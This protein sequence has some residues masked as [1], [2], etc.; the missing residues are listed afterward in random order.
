MERIVVRESGPG[1]IASIEELYPDAFPDEDLL[2]LVRELLKAKP[3]AL[4]LVGIIGSS[5]V[6]HVIF[7]T[8]GLAGSNNKVAL[9]GPLVVTAARRKHGIGSAI[10]RAGLLRLE[11][12]SMTHVF[13]LGDPGFY[14]RLGF[15]P[16]PHV[17]PPYPLP[18]EWRGAWQSMS[19]SSAV[20]PLP[21][22]TLSAPQPW[23]KPAL[24]TS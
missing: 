8:C 10:V 24:W 9:L 12:S 5:L 21:V 19:L 3:V 22:G 13:V 2:P 20:P 1:D 11:S 18:A 23:L 16:E 6:A 15:E 4:S 17:A 7:T 14:G